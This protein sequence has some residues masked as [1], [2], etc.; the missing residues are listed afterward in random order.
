MAVADLQKRIDELE[1]CLFMVST[2]IWRDKHMNVCGLHGEAAVVHLIEE[3]LGDK[4]APCEEK[5]FAKEA[6]E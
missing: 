3:T 2:G 1:S 6:I 5:D 4:C